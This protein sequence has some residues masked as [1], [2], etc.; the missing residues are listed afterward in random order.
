MDKENGINVIGHLASASGLGNTARLFVQLLLGLGRPVAVFDVDSDWTGKVA[1]VPGAISVSSV[2]KLPFDTNLLVVAAQVLPGILLRRFP[3]LLTP[4]FTNAA[5]LFWEL[6]VFPPA[7]VP[8]VRL[9]DLLVVC[10]RYVQ[11][12]FETSIPDVPTAFVEHPIPT[13]SGP[14]DAASARARYGIG[15][16]DFLVSTSFDM[17]SDLA[18]KNPLAVLEAFTR[19]FPDRSDVRLLVKANQSNG[20]GNEHS[21]ARRV[22]EIVEADPRIVFTTETLPHAEVLDLYGASDVYISLHRSEGLGLGPMEAMSRGVLTIAT[23]HSGNLT[24]MHEHNS[25]LVPYRLVPPRE[26]RWQFMS[27]FAG[28]NAAWAEPDVDAAASALQWAHRDPEARKRL[29]KRGQA[30]IEVRQQV[31]W[32]A[33]SLDRALSESRATSDGQERKRRKRAAMMAEL[34]SP[35]LMHR[36][37]DS[38]VYRLRQIGERHRE[39]AKA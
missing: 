8:S 21:I 15:A 32:K 22:M 11:Q 5:V 2:D 17:A 23:G 29:G 33:E 4:R 14:V 25:V 38:A 27:A 30:D 13:G 1:E 20:G 37:F 28:R 6:Q 34:L 35:S 26:T 3:V 24:Y 31:A 19:A 7:W 36:N 12:M 10:S 9:L 39:R 16:Q 18:R